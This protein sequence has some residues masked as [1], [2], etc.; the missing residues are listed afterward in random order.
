MQEFLCA[1][2]CLKETVQDEAFIEVWR[3]DV[4][5]NGPDDIIRKGWWQQVIQMY[6]DL[7]KS[8]SSAANPA[9]MLSTAVG[10]SF[11]RL[12]NGSGDFIVDNV[13]DSNVLTLV[14]MLRG[15]THLQA[16]SFEGNRKQQE[17]RI[18]SA[19]F[20]PFCALKLQSLTKIALPHQEIGPGGAASLASFMNDGSVPLLQQLDVR[21]NELLKG[22]LKPSYVARQIE[23]HEARLYGGWC[24][25]CYEQDDLGGFTSLIEAVKQH[26]SIES[27]DFRANYLGRSAGELLVGLLGVQGTKLRSVNAIQIVAPTEAEKGVAVLDYTPDGQSYPLETGGVLLLAEV[28]LKHPRPMLK[29]LLLA[30]QAITIDPGGAPEAFHKLGQAVAAHQQLEVLDVSEF[31]DYGVPGGRA[32]AEAIFGGDQAR[33][34]AHPSLKEIKLGYN[35]SI[36]LETLLEATEI[37]RDS[38][39]DKTQDPED[40]GYATLINDF[41]AGVLGVLAVHCRKLETVDLKN[42]YVVCRS[43]MSCVICFD[44]CYFV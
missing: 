27:V 5:P 42:L 2:Q 16:I 39:D 14:S 3:Q 12:G 10:A 17:Q 15:N 6:C 38:F 13:N 28:L 32:L 41:G 19:G 43:K 40:Y 30:S 34:R 21:C 9:I 7:A 35:S 33:M 4:C 44:L 25:D 8:H 18:T 29:H 26:P 37:S 36:K 23:R 11:L 1:E 22:G 31:W 24:N 20:S